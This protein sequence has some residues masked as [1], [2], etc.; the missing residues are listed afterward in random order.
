M[1][2][3]MAIIIIGG[4]LFPYELDL[5]NMREVK[6]VAPFVTPFLAHALGSIV[7]GSCGS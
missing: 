4:T 7:G 3:N 5:N 1:V 2:A 6:E